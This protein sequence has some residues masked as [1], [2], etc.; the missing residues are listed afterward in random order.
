MKAKGPRGPTISRAKVLRQVSCALLMCAIICCCYADPAIVVSPTGDDQA[1]G[2]EEAPFATLSRARDEARARQKTGQG[3]VAVWLRGGTYYLT[4]PIVFTE[5]DSGGSE[6]P[7]IYR[8]FGN[9]VPV[10]VGGLRITQWVPHND[11]IWKA[12]IPP[13]ANTLPAKFQVIEDSV[14]ATLARSPSE[15]WFRLRDPQIE[16]FWSFCYDEREF[17]ASNV[18]TSQLIV[19]LIQ[20]GTYFSEHIP[21]ERVDTGQ[22]RFYTKFKMKDPAY[23]PV[24]GKTFVVENALALLDAPGEYFADHATGVLYYMPIASDP[25]KA[26][27]V[28]DTAPQLLVIRGKDRDNQ[29]HGLRFEGIT[30]D[31]GTDQ[32]AIT[33]GARITFKD[34]R[35]LRASNTALSIDGASTSVNVTGCEIAHCGNYGISIHGE[36]ERREQGPATVYN[37]GHQIHDN[38]IHHVGRRTITGCGIGLHWS[39][40]D[41]VISNNLITDSPK[42]GIIMFSMW[43]MPRELAIMNNNVIR[44]NELARCVSSSWDG[45]AFYIGATTENNTF[46]NNRITDVWSWFNATWPQPEDR[47]EDACAI[48]FDPGMT[49]NTTI[50]NNVAYGPNATVLEFGRYADETF[51]E[52][53]YFESPDLPGEMLVNGKWEKNADFDASKVSTEI[54]LTTAFKLPY[55]KEFPRPI[56]FPLHCGF[57]GTLSPFHLYR[58]ND[59]LRQEFLTSGTIHDG[60]SAI[61]IDKDVMLLRYRH[62]EAISKKVALWFYDDTSKD[63]ASCLATLRGPSA[64]DEAVIALGVDGRVSK[65]HYVIREWQ[66]RAAA[67]E[68][69]RSTGWHELVFDVKSEKNEVTQLSIDGQVVGRVPVF[70]S[71]TTIELGDADFATDSTGLGF[72]SLKIE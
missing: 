36:Y 44:N 9:E 35:L 72:D 58:Y 8:S 69:S 30:F 71:F 56:A 15:G 13:I 7:I 16:P 32:I 12:A 2:T 48:D 37:H 39:A 65:S 43:D 64:I 33:H 38:Y 26:I 6:A 66:D 52:N 18:D 42:S 4:E 63:R 31:G 14:T 24:N 49:Y 53:N 17:D 59:G 61:R 47:P 60:N 20:M 25:S 46:E 11:R 1:A 29:V 27:I 54:G 5:T 3:Q 62:P 41:N 51:L 55:P 67:T 45:G 70:R 50:R 10:V 22:R 23:D 57:E 40:N 34:C 19:N 68:I 28:A 21:I